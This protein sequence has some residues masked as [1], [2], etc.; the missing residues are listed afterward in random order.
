MHLQHSPE[1]PPTV[2]S[3][4]GFHA[5]SLLC[6]GALHGEPTAFTNV[7]T[8]HHCSILARSL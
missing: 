1:A 4:T 8:V 7:L 6:A 2:L 5:Q 3:S